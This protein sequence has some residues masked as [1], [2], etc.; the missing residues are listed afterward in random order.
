MK[1]VV[2]ADIVSL[3][4]FAAQTNE[5]TIEILRDYLGQAE[6]GEIVAVAIAAVA[7]GGA[8]RTQA[9]ASDNF[10]GLLGA[11]LILQYR[12]LTESKTI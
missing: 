1:G 6:R 2:M 4:T 7:P 11:M 10:Q 9:S 3:K 5:A 8:S 12:M